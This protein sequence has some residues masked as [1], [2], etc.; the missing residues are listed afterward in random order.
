MSDNIVNMR[1]D[2]IHIPGTPIEGV[3]EAL[4]WVLKRAKDGEIDGIAIAYIHQDNCTNYKIVGRMTRALTG[5]IAVMNAKML[6]ED[7]TDED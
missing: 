3:I 5:T 6:F 7:M 4:E 1:G 2:N